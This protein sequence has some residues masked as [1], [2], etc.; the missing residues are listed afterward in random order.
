[1]PLFDNEQ[2]AVTEE[3]LCSVPPA[4]PFVYKI[5]V[6]RLLEKTLLGDGEY[7]RWPIHM[8]AKTW[9]DIE[10]FLEAYR[11]AVELHANECLDPIDRSLLTRSIQKGRDE[12]ARSCGWMS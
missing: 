4:A 1:M 11:K 9:I 3:G 10:A 6:K 5:P 12:A 2:W 8:A 7:Y